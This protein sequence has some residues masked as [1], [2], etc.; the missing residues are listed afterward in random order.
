MATYQSTVVIEPDEGGYHA[1]A[2]LSPGCH[3][4]GDAIEEARAHITEAIELHVDSI[5]EDGEDVPIEREPV[6]VTR[7]SVPAPK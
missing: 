7:L 3:S 5:T 4:F 6:F 1:F 2:P